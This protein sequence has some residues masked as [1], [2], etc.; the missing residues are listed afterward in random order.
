LEKILGLARLVVLGL[1]FALAGCVTAENSLSQNDIAGMK[2]TAVNVSFAP[3]ALVQFEDGIRAYATSKAIPDDQI[4]TAANTPEGK[5]FVNNMLGPRIKAEIERVMAGQL[6]GARPVRL[7]VVVRSFELPSAVQRILIGGNRAMTA[8]A[9][10]VDARTGAVI[11]A[12][13]DLRT[14]AYTGQGVLGTAIQA[15]VDNS[16]NQG[17]VE[18]VVANY[19][20][21]YRSWLL[22]QS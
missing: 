6:N 11:L 9:T 18:R 15:G 17:V 8:D 20:E 2:L 19:G 1:A 16:S 21:T 7:E 13:A 12:Y 3:N 4:S 22:R 10:L 5:A 14:Q